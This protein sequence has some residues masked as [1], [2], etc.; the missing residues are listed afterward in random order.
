MRIG[1][2]VMVQLSKRGVRVIVICLIHFFR[3]LEIK[4]LGMD[5]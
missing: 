3:I 1:V 2:V 5:L 4:D